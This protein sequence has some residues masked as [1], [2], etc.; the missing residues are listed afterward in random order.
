MCIQGIF[1]DIWEGSGL[2]CAG[3]NESSKNN[4]LSWSCGLIQT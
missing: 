2:K 1:W 4:P 3:S